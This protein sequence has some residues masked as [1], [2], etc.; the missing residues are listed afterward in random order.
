VNNCQPLTGLA[1]Q[2]HNGDVQAL[3]D[4]I[5]RFFQGVAADLHP[6]EDNC[7]PP[8]PEV[9]QDEFIISLEDVECRLSQ[10][11]VHKAP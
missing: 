3:A 4:S 5:N 11:D 2:L 10:I 7:T 1:N 8:P 6:L 9:I